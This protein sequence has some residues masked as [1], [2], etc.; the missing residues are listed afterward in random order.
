MPILI[1]GKNEFWKSRSMSTARNNML[2]EVDARTNLVGHNRLELLLFRL[3]GKQRYGINVFK[4]REVINCPEITRLPHANEA[5]VG[6]TKLRG[7]TFMIIDIQHAMGMEPLTNHSECS[8]IVSEYNR[9]MQGFLIPH[10]EL[11][12]NKNW[13]EIQA[14]PKVAGNDNYLTAVTRIDD[15]L[16]EI[17]DVEKILMEICGGEYATTEQDFSDDIN[18]AEAAKQCHILV[19][20]DSVVARKQI[21]R[22]LDKME[23]PCTLC[24]DGKAA[25]D[26]L[27]TWADKEAEEFD[28]LALVISDVEM[29]EMDGYTLTS[30][31]RNNHKLKHLTI[32][33]HTSLSGVFDSSLLEKVKAD[34]F[35]AKFD[36]DELST[37]V[38]EK[39]ENFS[40]LL[41]DRGLIS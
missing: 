5:V 17:I 14:P 32:L 28:R 41:K 40:K 38:K 3:S 9:K 37:I 12:V 34:G 2:Q 35:L 21:K 39:I 4:V 11:I 33:L 18:F 19:A 26:Q 24:N 27:I 7:N 8:V 1:Q 16:I 10:V 20:D 36:A 23:I 22:V 29:P 30:E 6:I 25:L 13:E 15:E 31:I